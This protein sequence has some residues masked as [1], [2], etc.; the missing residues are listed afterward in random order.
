MMGYGGYEPDAYGREEA[1]D[2]PVDAAD[3]REHAD[4]SA[5]PTWWG[6]LVSRFRRA[7]R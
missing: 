5:A 4:E 2:F 3:S 6:R 1:S 7:R